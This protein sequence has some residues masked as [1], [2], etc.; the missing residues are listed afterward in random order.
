MA[1]VEGLKEVKER[2]AS[3]GSSLVNTKGENVRVMD[4][5]SMSDG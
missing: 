4:E 2:T 5:D 1:E 3:E